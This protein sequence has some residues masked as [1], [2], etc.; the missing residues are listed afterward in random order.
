MKSHIFAFWVI[1]ISLAG[2][3][4]AQVSRPEL[5]IV[6]YGDNTV[7]SLYGIEAN[8]VAGKQMFR[9]A[10][11]I[12]FSDLGGLVAVNG[13]IQ[14]VDLRGSV[15]GEYN[16]HERKPVLNI[17][18]GLTTAVAYL[19]SREALLHWSGESFV[20]TQLGSGSFS[21]K[22]T[23]VRMLGPRSAQLLAT[24][25]DGNVSE[26][27]ISLDTSQPTGVK[28]LPGIRGP[29]FLHHAFVLFHDEQGL[30]VEAANGSRRTVPMLAKDLAIERMS[31]DWLHLTSPSTKQSWALH[32]NNTS[33]QLSE[34][35]FFGQREHAK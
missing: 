34:M 14:L 9:T 7:R 29:A 16:S 17:D 20:L 31:S 22:A 27:T 23:S 33:L 24:T 19:P 26:I 12:S 5:G 15:L 3:L 30:E 13:H 2:S 25:S 18:G 4:H 21:G 11:A 35:P 32:L 6:R 28:F 8:L 1:S 10:D